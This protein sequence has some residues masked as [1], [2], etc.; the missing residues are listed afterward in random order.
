MVVELAEL[1]NVIYLVL[2]QSLLVFLLDGLIFD[3][4]FQTVRPGFVM[5]SID[6]A[7]TFSRFSW[8]EVQQTPFFY[9]IFSFSTSAASSTLLCLGRVIS[10]LPE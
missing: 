7:V 3:Y 5:Y 9:V 1:L 8:R 2:L 6:E 10:T 4:L